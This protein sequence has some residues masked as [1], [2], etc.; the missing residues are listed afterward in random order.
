MWLFI[1]HGFFSAVAG[2]DADGRPD[3]DTIVVRAR[4]RRHLV[5]LLSAT[6]TRADVFESDDTDYPCRIVIGRAM[7]T[8]MLEDLS[9]DTDYT[10]FKDAAHDDADPAWNALLMNVW[11]A[12]NRY[13][14]NKQEE[15]RRAERRPTPKRRKTR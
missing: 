6:H 10:N 1:R 9:A 11:A 13:G 5:E 12:G 7:W 8:G 4:N 3:P 14:Q 2:K 15:V